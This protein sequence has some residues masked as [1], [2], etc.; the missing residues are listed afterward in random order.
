M[1]RMAESAHREN[2]LSA[3]RA[4]AKDSHRGYLQGLLA[5]TVAVAEVTGRIKI[6]D[7][8][9]QTWTLVNEIHK[10]LMALSAAEAERLD[11]C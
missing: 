5:A 3:V 6:A 10:A 1:N 11:R 7:M 9:D 2:M 4:G 8:T